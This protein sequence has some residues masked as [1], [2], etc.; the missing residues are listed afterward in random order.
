LG[1]LLPKRTD[2]TRHPIHIQYVVILE[3]FSKMKMDRKGWEERKEMQL[4]RSHK[5]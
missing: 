4:F 2:P 3:G 1:K 5:G